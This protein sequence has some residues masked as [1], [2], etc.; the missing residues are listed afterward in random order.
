MFWKQG[1]IV[2]R[3][4]LKNKKIKKILFFNLKF[5]YFISISVIFIFYIYIVEYQDLYSKKDDLKKKLN[6]TFLLF[7]LKDFIF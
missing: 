2:H 3:S 6:K 7:D 4:G 5:L 1:R